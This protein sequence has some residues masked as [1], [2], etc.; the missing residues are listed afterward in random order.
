MSNGVMHIWG[1]ISKDL[2]TKP[3]SVGGLVF[4][5]K[6]VFLG[7]FRREHVPRHHYPKKL[8]HDKAKGEGDQANM[9]VG[10]GR[11]RKGLLAQ[12]TMGHQ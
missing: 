3:T 5:K 11:S 1:S 8:C 12:V 4:C 2:G 10:S 9:F 7:W 6:G